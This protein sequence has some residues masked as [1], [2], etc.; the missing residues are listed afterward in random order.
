MPLR[1]FDNCDSLFRGFLKERIHTFRGF[2][3]KSQM[4]QRVNL[5]KIELTQLLRGHLMKREIIIPCAQVHILGVRL[6]YDFHI[7]EEFIKPLGNL[8][9]PHPE[10]QMS[11]ATG[12]SL[13]LQVFPLSNEEIFQIPQARC[14]RTASYPGPREGAR[15]QSIAESSQDP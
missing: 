13:L 2:H 8:D 11:K 3:Q 5:G 6:P 1:G 4:I 10:G 12:F 9:I 14:N 7:K 15:C